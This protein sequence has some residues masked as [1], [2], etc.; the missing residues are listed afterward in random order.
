[1]PLPVAAG[2]AIKFAPSI[3][4][5]IG[6]LFGNRAKENAA[7]D[8]ARLQ[9]EF[10]AKTDAAKA[11]IL[12]MLRASGWNPAGVNRLQSGSTTS[13][14]TNEFVRPEILSAYRGIE[15]KLKSLVEN[16]LGRGQYSNEEFVK[17]NLVNRVRAIN[18]ANAGADAAVRN[19]SPGLSPAQRAALA[20]AAN[21]S[22]TGQIADVVGNIPMEARGLENEDFARAQGLTESFGK[23][24]RTTTNRLSNTSGW[25]D[26]GPDLNSFA[27]LLMPTAPMASMQT[28]RSLAGDILGGAADL[29]GALAQ[30]GANRGWFDKRPR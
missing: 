6:S 5:G 29:T 4:K 23:G 9:N 3:I 26:V 12:E 22:R 20:Q 1:M 14:S 15:S 11:K 24:T 30:W 16:R 18:A 21:I 17:R 7:K 19:A 25:K 10:L 13:E 8:Q 27:P 28:G 2:L